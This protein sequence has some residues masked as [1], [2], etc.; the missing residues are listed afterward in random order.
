LVYY[1]DMSRLIDWNFSFLLGEDP[2]SD[3]GWG[4][5][6]SGF[7][8]FILFRL[9]ESGRYIYLGTT[10][11]EL[12]QYFRI[13]SYNFVFLTSHHIDWFGRSVW[14]GI[15][16]VVFSA[17]FLNIYTVL[18]RLLS[19]SMVAEKAPAIIRV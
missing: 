1:F 13:V 7:L 12:A 5:I 9:T 15:V 14:W 2:R 4:R 18:R 6:I 16:S 11:S 19:A 3:F 8:D 17:L 10:A